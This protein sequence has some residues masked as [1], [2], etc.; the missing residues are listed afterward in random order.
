MM[1]DFTS[2]ETNA[3]IDWIE[4]DDMRNE[5][6]QQLARRALAASGREAAISSIS[7]A[8]YDAVEQSLPVT[9][10]IASHLLPRALVRVNF[11][12]IAAAL[13]REVA[14]EAQPA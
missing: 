11:Y 6:W 1:V 10:G 5:Q 3:V 4:A 9:E 14:E 12:E 2:S 7:D 8:L 13:I